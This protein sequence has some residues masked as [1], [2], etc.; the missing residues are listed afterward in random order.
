LGDEEK[1]GYE[2]AEEGAP[3]AEWGNPK[4]KG[5]DDGEDSVEDGAKSA[6]GDTGYVKWRR[7][8]LKAEL[9]IERWKKLWTWRPT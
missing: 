4:G 8:G 9:T 2:G 7:R 1:G 5:R 6:W 3:E